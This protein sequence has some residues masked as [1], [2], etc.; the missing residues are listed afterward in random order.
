MA[1]TVKGTAHLYGISGTVASA[2]VLSFRERTFAANTAQTEDED[3]NV[4]W[5]YGPVC[6]PP[7]WLAKGGARAAFEGQGGGQGEHHADVGHQP[8]CRC[9]IVQIADDGAAD[10]DAGTGGDAL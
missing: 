8:L 7:D 9:A 10:D 4:D 3:G 1:A 6:S 5:V 2:T